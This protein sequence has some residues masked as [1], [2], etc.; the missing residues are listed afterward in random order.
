L[1][2]V[3]LLQKDPA[4]EEILS[5]FHKSTLLGCFQPRARVRQIAWLPNLNVFLLLQQKP[6]VDAFTDPR[7]AT[8]FGQCYLREIAIVASQCLI[9]GKRPNGRPGT[10][11]QDKYVTVGTVKVPKD[12]VGIEVINCSQSGPSI[13]IALCTLTES[14]QYAKIDLDFSLS[15]LTSFTTRETGSGRLFNRPQA[16]EVDLVA[17]YHYNQQTYMLVQTK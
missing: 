10:E 13:S 1:D 16:V 2:L 12:T 14:G 4:D 7:S 17:S 5:V 8:E 15:D 9:D 11:Q 3:A 6:D